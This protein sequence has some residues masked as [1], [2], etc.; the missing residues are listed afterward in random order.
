VPKREPLSAGA[1]EIVQQLRDGKPWTRARLAAAVG[2]SRSTVALRIEELA[3]SGLVEDVGGAVQTGGRPSARIALSPRARV[4][5]AADLGATHASTAILDLVGTP[6]AYRR[7]PT[8]RDDGPEEILEWV[9]VSAAEMLDELHIAESGLAAAAVGLA[10][11]IEHSTGRPINP[12]VMPRWDGY[13]VSGWMRE[14][15][16]VPTLVEKDVNLMAVGEHARRWRHA[17]NLIFVKMATGIGAGLILSGSLHRGTQGIAGDIGH[18]RLSDVGDVPCRCGNRGCLEAVASG[19]ALAQRLSSGGHQVGS[20]AEVL[21]LI[22]SGDLEAIQA[23]RQAGRYLGEALASATS[24]LNPT[25]VV[26]GGSLAQTGE[27]L[28]AGAREIVYSRAMPLATQQLS[29]V[30]ASPEDNPAIT[31]AGILAAEHA[32]SAAD[33]GKRRP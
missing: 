18:M 10:A 15:L 8:T 13:E 28:L 26:I 11:P 25:T 30:Q 31:G 2:M 16:V 17:D 4:V 3:A 24:L 5:L 9:A 21:D 27:H 19:P 7:R 29:I 14:R 23:V 32:L 33:L 12:P 1:I 20:T 22:R 6:L